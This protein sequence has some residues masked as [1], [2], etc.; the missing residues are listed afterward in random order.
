MAKDWMTFYYAEPH[1]ERFVQEVRQLSAQGQLTQ[2]E[3]SLV[4]TTFL[5]GVMAANPLQV[6]AWLDAL[7]DLPAGD[8]RS[9]ETAVWLSAT[10]E[11]KAYLAERK[12]ERFAQTPPDILERAIDRPIVLDAL[13]AHY[14]ATGNLHAV[15]RIISV[16]EYMTDSGAA[17]SFRDSAQTDLDQERAM[18]GALFQ[19]ASWSLGSLLREHPPLLAFC[20]ELVRSDELATTQRCAL[21]IVLSQVDPSTWRV[22]IDQNT[23]KVSI[24][25]LDA[26]APT[27]TRKRKPWWKVW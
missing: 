2:V 13:W 3:H 24:A 15:R 27:P 19:A 4:A 9:L 23:N 16:L 8:L 18:R 17:Q 26:V 12:D 5:S 21:A 14:F 10:S 22:T 6:R 1:P 7:S 20:G 25:W 11:A